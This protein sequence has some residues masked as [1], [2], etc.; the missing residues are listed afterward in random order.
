MKKQKINSGRCTQAILIHNACLIIGNRI[1]GNSWILIKDAKIFRIGYG[2][3][4]VLKNTMY[5]DAR[6]GYVAPG[7]IDLHI[8]GNLSKIS[9]IQAKSGTTGFLLSLHTR[10]LNQFSKSLSEFQDTL[11]KGARCLGFHLE[12][13]FISKKMAGAQ[14]KRFMIDPDIQAIRS[15]IKK[16]EKKIKIITIAPELKNSIALIK[17][18]K[19]DKI[20]AAIGHTDASI[21]QAKMAIDNGCLYTTHVFN[22]MSGIS[23]RNPGVITQ[24]LLDNRISAEVIADAYHVHPDNLRLLV[25]CKPQDKIVLVSDS[26]AAMDSRSLKVIAGVYRMENLALNRT[27][28]GSRYTIAGSK[29]NMLQ[30]V[31]NMVYLCG[32]S[33]ANAVKMAS[34]NPARVIG[35]DRKKGRIANGYDADIVIFDKDF[36]CKATITAGEIIFRR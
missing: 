18:L 31:K 2:A 24:V 36:Q 26:V 10:S 20:V 6:S 32:V 11:P 35:L 30:A 29:L 14:P 28:S 3:K 19:K 1:T 9:K 12:G 22:R 7:F 27:G 34:L 8:H 21:E 5:I 13:P 16:A 33:I 17:M 4:P 15:L 23:S 25:K